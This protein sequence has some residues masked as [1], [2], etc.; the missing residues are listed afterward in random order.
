MTGRSSTGARTT[1]GSWSSSSAAGAAPFAGIASV[2]IGTDPVS[3]GASAGLSAESPPG[4]VAEAAEAGDPE[5]NAGPST[6][7]IASMS[8]ASFAPPAAGRS[9][10]VATPIAR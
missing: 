10:Q 4:S 9:V 8:L 2:T 3:A 6:R 7:V 1:R 5:E